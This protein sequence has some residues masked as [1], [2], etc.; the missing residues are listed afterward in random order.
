MRFDGFELEPQNSCDKKVRFAFAS[1]VEP[2]YRFHDAQDKLREAV[3]AAHASRAL[4]N[5][6]M[7]PKPNLGLDPEVFVAR[8]DGS[9]LPAFEFLPEKRPSNKE[10]WD[11]YQA[12]FLVWAG[13]CIAQRVDSIQERLRAITRKFPE[14]ASFMPQDV[15]G[16]DL[17]AAK[18]LPER[19]T[20]LGCDPSYHIYGDQA[21]IPEDG[22]ELPYR[23]A[24]GH[25]HFGADWII[26]DKP[27]I[28]QMVKDLDKILAVWSVGAAASWESSKVRRRYYGL[29]GEFRTPAHGLEYRTLSNFFLSAPEIAHITLEIARMAVRSSLAGFTKFWKANEEDVR[30]V[31]NNYDR[32]GAAKMLKENEQL[33][34][35]LLSMNVSYWHAFNDKTNLSATGARDVAEKAVD[36]AFQVGLE[37]IEIVVPKPGSIRENWFLD[38]FEGI[39]HV[40]ERGTYHSWQALAAKL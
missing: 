20:M 36:K 38:T 26:G 18:L 17:K 9:L 2:A 7:T 16:I 1:D 32:A 3:L 22:C 31:I 25:I 21:D 12:E 10:F 34:K 30:N 11:G 39:N 37:G 23:F 4:E 33:F 29:A 13:G 24:G 19:Y 15:V 40:N 27:R 14:G 6:S 5:F 35:K 28:T 8:K